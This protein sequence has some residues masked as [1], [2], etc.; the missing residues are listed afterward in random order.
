MLANEQIGPTRYPI[1]SKNL[2]RQRGKEAWNTNLQLASLAASKVASCLGPMGA[3]K[4]VT[5]H[6]GAELVTKVTKDAVDIVDE[7]GVQYPAIKTIAE[8]AKIHRQEAGDGVSTLL[9]IVAALLEEAQRLIEVGVHPVAILDGY[10]EAAKKS[11]DI[12]DELAFSFS[13]DLE[14]AL[15]Q[16]IDSGRGLLSKRLRE[17]LAGAIH[18]VKDQ[19]GVDLGRRSIK[20][21][22]SE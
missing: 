3:Y 13:E 1:F 10:K 20:K 16:I 21:K 17:E 4:L 8:A 19:D 15:L 5:Y 2:G 12:I 9:V 22:Q 7:L 11:I 14:D 18:L 6:R